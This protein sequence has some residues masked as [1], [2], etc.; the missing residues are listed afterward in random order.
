MKI[1]ACIK[2]DIRLICGNGFKGVLLLAFPVLLLFVLGMFMRGMA[3]ENEYLRPFSIAVRDEDDTT[4]SHILISQ[5]RNIPLFEEV[6]TGGTIDD[7]ALFRQDCV[8]VITIPK[9]FFYDIY[10]RRDTDL[11]V[12]LNPDMP[13]EALF[14][15]SSFGSL[16]GILEQNQRVYYAEAK[17]RYG[18]LD[19]DAKDRV[20]DH[21]S[22]ATI[23]DALQRLDY[24]E[25]EA[26]YSDQASTE[27]TFFCISVVSM[28]LL[29]IPLCIVR[30]LHEEKEL[31][32][33]ERLA[34]SNHGSFHMVLSK[35]IASTV[36]TAVPVAAVL[37]LTRLPNAVSLIPAL[38]ILFLA[39]F[40]FFLLLSLVAKSSE[41]TQLIGNMIMLL[42]LVV[43][44]A[45]F[46]YRIIPRQVRFVSYAT[47]PYYVMRT[48]Y[49]ASLG[50]SALEIVRTVIPAACAIPVFLSI[51]Y[52]L[53]KRPFAGS[54][55]RK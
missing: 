6:I 54:E 3:N 9:D 50:R 1:L 4:E 38:L 48:F 51:S 34:A 35:L 30:N 13:R 42:M 53:Y 5:L 44:G 37:L 24:F 7:E 12:E 20:A 47:L 45:L 52:V 11:H 29:F 49:A 43:G 2:K 27:R 55:V 41:R 19:E 31:G 25:I 23:N 32:I 21:F 10:Y 40:S 26:L 15:R 16:I 28:L 17:I 18:E 36:L 33:I 8:A 39:S 22:N 46:P 14:V